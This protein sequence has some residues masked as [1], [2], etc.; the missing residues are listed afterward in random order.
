[1]VLEIE[2]P[3][4]KTVRLITDDRSRTAKKGGS[5]CTKQQSAVMMELRGVSGALVSCF[6]ACFW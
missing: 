3:G 5:K 6:P 1:M 4:E 2:K